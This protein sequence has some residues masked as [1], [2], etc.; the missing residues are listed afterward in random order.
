[1]AENTAPRGAG[2][3]VM[4][5]VVLD[6]SMS[7]DGFIAGPT[8]GEAEPMG[9]GGERLHAWM[10]GN[11]LDAQIVAAGLLGRASYEGGATTAA[12]GLPLHYSSRCRW[13]SPT[14]WCRAVGTRCGAGPCSTARRT[15]SCCMA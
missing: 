9:D 2:E 5:K 8:V 7:L 6:V 14:T 12:L 11:G 3:V 15:D 10:A 4:S 1:M 13:L